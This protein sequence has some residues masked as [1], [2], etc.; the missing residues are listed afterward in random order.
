[1]NTRLKLATSASDGS[2]I[3]YGATIVQQDDKTIWVEIPAKVRKLPF[4]PYNGKRFVQFALTPA[5]RKQI[6][7]PNCR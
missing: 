4:P 7:T 2:I 5:L 1:M 6:F 3:T